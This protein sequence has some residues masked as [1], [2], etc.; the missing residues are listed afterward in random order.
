MYDSIVI[1]VD[2]SDEARRAAQYGLRLAQVFDATVDVLSVVERKALWL[3][4][5]PDEKTQLREQGENALTEVGEIASE[6]GYPI[7]TELTEGKPT[8]QISEYADEQDSDLIVLGRQGLTGLGRRLLGGV[9]EQVLSR[10]DVPV[11]VVPDIDHK[12]KTEIDYS[13]VLIT[14]D[15]SKNAE[16]A[17][18]HGIEITRRYDSNVHVLNV[19]DLQAAGGVFNA[20]GLE[21]EFIERLDA[22]GQEAVDSV[23]DKIEE[24]D[25]DL[26]VKTAVKQMASFERTA[27]GVCEYVEENKID[28]IIMG[29]HG[30]SNLERQLL[31]SVASTVLRTVDVPVLV[32]KRTG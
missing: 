6:L 10:S 3:T 28:F 5:T 27:A 11:L 24:S 8:V 26:T 14:T 30:R 29:S 32:I 21:K 19:V 18:P 23:A 22:R 7:S 20:G 13:R 4:E 16:V 9:T 25:S 12:G 1:A 17:I 15:G 31:G 2:G